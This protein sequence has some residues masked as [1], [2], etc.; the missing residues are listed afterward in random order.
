MEKI[1][2]FSEMLLGWILKIYFASLII[3]TLL[4]NA[5]EGFAKGNLFEKLNNYCFL[6][7]FLL[8]IIDFIKIC[9]GKKSYFKDLY[10]DF[11]QT[12]QIFKTKKALN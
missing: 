2:N 11:C 8:I 6:V 4:N 7:L 1:N 5:P 3:T 12:L 9:T 10:I